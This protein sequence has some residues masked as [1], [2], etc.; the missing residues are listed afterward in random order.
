M[1]ELAAHL[2]HRLSRSGAR[3]GI[4]QVT[5]RFRLRE[6]HPTVRERAKGEL[7]CVRHSRAKMQTKINNAPKKHRRSVTTYLDDIFPG[8]GVRRLKVCNDRF[9]EN[10]TAVCVAKLLQLRD[11]RCRRE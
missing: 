3:L 9:V 8:E 2:A 11:A 4:D 1:R 10:V 6:I 5:D 7:T